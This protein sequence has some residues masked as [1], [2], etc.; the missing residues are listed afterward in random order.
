M[1]VGV[2]EA[3]SV[4][5]LI[6]NTSF[7]IDGDFFP[8]R[9]E[10]QKLAVER[11]A[12]YLFSVNAHSQIALASL[13][14]SQY[15]VRVSFTRLGP[16]LV[17]ALASV[18]PSCG[19]AQL[20]RAI[21]WAL[22]AFHHAQTAARHILTFIGG[23][24]DVADSKTADT[25][26][27]MIAEA[28]VYVDIV[29]IGPDVKHIPLLR[30]LSEGSGGYYIEVLKSD[31]VLSDNVLA[32][33]IGPGPNSRIQVAEYAKS[34]PDFAQALSMS[35]EPPKA[36]RQSSLAMLLQPSVQ[37]PRKSRTAKITRVGKPSK[38]NGG[39]SARDGNADLKKK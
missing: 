31:T 15:G 29:A 17:T 28:R 35:I 1:T 37:I 16:R 33:S 36:P 32:S 30:R 39:D 2:S 38:E 34:D 8:T 14:S 22:I 3:R 19:I 24:H 4:V 18:T 11:Y 9:L 23:E 21:Q 26:A 5:V 25:L 7:S 20:A 13:S 6:D 27:L 10:A 12:Q